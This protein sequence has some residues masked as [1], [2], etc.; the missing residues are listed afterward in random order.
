[1]CARYFFLFQIL[2]AG[3]VATREKLTDPKWH[4]C[5]R[6]RQTGKLHFS[7][8]IAIRSRANLQRDYSAA[9]Y[10]LGERHLANA[11]H[12]PHCLLLTSDGEIDLFLLF[13]LDS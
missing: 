10:K 9:P 7:F 12:F 1:M 5:A 11:V 4:M 13:P 2:N 8:F 3:A 6:K